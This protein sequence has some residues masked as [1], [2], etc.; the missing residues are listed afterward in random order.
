MQGGKPHLGLD[1][2]VCRPG[3]RPKRLVLEVDT[4][5]LQLVEDRRD[6]LGVQGLDAASELVGPDLLAPEIRPGDERGQQNDE[7]DTRP[8]KTWPVSVRSNAV[9]LGRSEL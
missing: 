4:S 3:F 7:T 5:G 8:R 9:E 6:P 2:A 1:Q